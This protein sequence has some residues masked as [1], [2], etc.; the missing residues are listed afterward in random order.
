MTRPPPLRP[1]C[2]IGPPAAGKTTLAEALSRDLDAP[3]LRPRD[4]VDR[5][6]NSYP[7]TLPLFPHDERGHVPDE[8]LC[9]ALRTCLDQ[10]SGMV[11]LESIP[12]DAIQLADLHCVAGDR[13]IVLHLNA[14]DNLVT[15]RRTG[16][17]HCPKC[18]PLSTSVTDQGDC[19]RCG[20]TLT[21]RNDDEETAFA[22]RLNAHR[23][24]AA[25]ILTL[26][27]N[28]RVH[29]VTL[30][31]TNAPGALSSQALA[32]LDAASKVVAA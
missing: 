24:N 32:A 22:E 31:A 18:Y 28:L 16:R 6:V 7:G 27:R 9:L 4:L 26:A 11:L 29:V 13:V 23:A 3:I 19:A 15:E 14:A 25:R 5:T 21:P 8:S 17:R 12:W 30:D 2:L 1:I 10:L 20:G